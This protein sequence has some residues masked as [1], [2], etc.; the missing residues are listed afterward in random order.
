[1]RTW[2]ALHPRRILHVPGAIRIHGGFSPGESQIR[3]LQSGAEYSINWV[4][5]A[6][7]ILKENK[8]KEKKKRERNI[9][10]FGLFFMMDSLFHY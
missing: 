5:A 10:H 2:S 8:L 3:A 4:T 1:M 9:S 7:T 6:L